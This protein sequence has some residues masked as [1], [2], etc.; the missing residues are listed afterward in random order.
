MNRRSIA[1]L[2]RAFCLALV[3]TLVLVAWTSVQAAPLATI[4]MEGRR[5]GTT[6]WVTFLFVAPGDVIEYRLVA[7]MAPV[8]TTNGSNTI[9]SLA[10]SGLQ[11]LSLA[12]VQ[13]PGDTAQVDFNIPPPIAQGLRNGWGAGTGASTGALSPR[14]P[15]GW[16]DLRGIRP[17]HSPGVF[18]AADPEVILQ[19]GTFTVAGPSGP[20]FFGRITPSWG[21]ASGAMRIN[22]AGQIF[23]T[24]ND[25]TGPDPLV[26]FEPLVLNIPEPSTIALLATAL[27]GFVAMFRRRRA[28]RHELD[29]FA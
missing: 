11:S 23:I 17:I 20:F 12:I 2:N 21:T 7:D 26:R 29:R 24:A 15:G 4:F 18:S 28:A 5:A 16:N 8:G 1:K 27:A 6:A 9:T 22:G 3:G 25:Q 13:A 10:K 19:G 14:S